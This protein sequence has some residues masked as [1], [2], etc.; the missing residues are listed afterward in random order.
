[1][2]DSPSFIVSHIFNLLTFFSV[3]ALMDFRQNESLRIIDNNGNYMDITISSI[4]NANQLS[5]WYYC[6]INFRPSRCRKICKLFRHLKTDHIHLFQLLFHEIK[7]IEYC[8]TVKHSDNPIHRPFGTRISMISLFI[9]V[10]IPT[11]YWKYT[12]K[13]DKY[14]PSQ[15]AA[16]R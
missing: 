13:D 16:E 5:I 3:D 8:H 10:L 14:S 1:M 15:C 6:F 2:H 12:I 11:T 4:K 9:T 7:M